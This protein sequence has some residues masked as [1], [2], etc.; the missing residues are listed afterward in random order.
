MQYARACAELH[1][2]QVLVETLKK[3]RD[4]LLK[5]R[6]DEARARNGEEKGEEK[7]EDS[8]D[9]EVEEERE[10]LSLDPHDDER[11]FLE[12]AVAGAMRRLENVKLD[13]A[14]MTKAKVSVCAGS[15]GGCWSPINVILCSV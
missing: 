15:R 14:E 1:E 13:V 4:M 3:R 9:G 11:R 7:G 10:G 5:V 2:E 12:E 8:K 6:R